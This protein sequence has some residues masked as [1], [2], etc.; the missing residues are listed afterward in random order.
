MIKS[1]SKQEKLKSCVEEMLVSSLSNE[2][3]P[4]PSYFDTDLFNVNILM[5]MTLSS[6]ALTYPERKRTNSC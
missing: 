1:M 2:E 4:N 6:L 3:N 5:W